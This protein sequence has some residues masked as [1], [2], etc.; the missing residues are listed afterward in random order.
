VPEG[1]RAVIIFGVTLA[2]GIFIQAVA[3]TVGVALAAV[4][5]AEARPVFAAAAG[6]LR[7]L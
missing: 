6:V 5:F 7:K 4:I 2:V 1:R 3:V